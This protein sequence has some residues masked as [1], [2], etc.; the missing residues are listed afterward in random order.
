MRTLLSVVFARLREITRQGTSELERD[1][2]FR[3]HLEME[4]EHNRRRGMSES[5]ARRAAHLSFGGVQQYREATREARGFEPLDRLLRDAR[6]AARRLRRSPSFSFG[7]IATLGV[8]VGAAVAIGALV[9]GVMLRPLPFPEPDRI[10]QVAFRTPGFDGGREHAHSHATYLHFKESGRSFASFGGY[11][12]NDAVNLTDGDDPQRVSAVMATPGVLEVLRAVPAAGRLLSQQDA[13]VATPDVV[14]VMISHRLWQQRYG[15]DPSIIGRTIEVNRRARRVVGVLPAS[16]AF[17]LPV[18]TVWFP[19]DEIRAD[20]WGGRPSLQSRYVTVIARLRD[21]AD[22]ER[23]EQELDAAIPRFSERFPTIT[24]EQV[25]QS[26]AYAEVQPLKDAT[27][28]PVRQHLHLLG[29]TVILVLLI[30]GA[31]VTNLFLLRAERSRHE[32]AI[33]R[34]L[35]AGSGDVARRFVAEGAV[36]GLAG[37]VVALPIVSAAVTSRFGFTAREIPRLHEVT[38]TGKTVTA[39]VA[40]ALVL[41][42]LVSLVAFLR[43]G[44]ARMGLRLQVGSGKVTDRWGVAQRGLVAA[45]VGIALT[46]LVGAA[47]LGRT[48]W[49]LR[50]AELGFMLEGRVTLE[51]TLPYRGYETYARAAAFHAAVMDRLRAIPGVQGADA[52]MEIPLIQEHP[53]E[54]SFELAAVGTRKSER[55]AVNMASPEYFKLMG[56]PLLH[57]RRFAAGDI[58]AAT[59]AIVLSASLARALFDRTDV[60]GRLVRAPSPGDDDVFHQVVGVVGDVPRWRIEDGPA[61][62]AYFPLLRDGDGV[63]PD[64]ARVPI[65]MGT[66]RYVLRTDAPVAQLA[67]SLRSAV[68]EVDARVPVTNVTSLPAIVDAATARVRLTML[69]LGVSAAAALL[70]G[71]IGIYSIVSYTV[72]GRQRELGV[73]LALGATPSRI[74]RMV[75]RDGLV[76]TAAGVAVG[77]VSALWAGRVVQSMLY[78]VSATDPVLYAGVT[79]VLVLVGVAATLAPAHRAAHVNPIEV[80]RAE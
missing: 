55:G 34:A 80:I 1:E 35:G 65:L 51:V 42:A 73:R 43:A 47:L 15:R 76:L 11:H 4:T 61:R 22:I 45:Q 62:M 70:L 50:H 29:V 63:H 7:V 21:G 71:V 57:G 78:G 10:V 24:A 77:L 8:G 37:A 40:T 33:A 75:L 52:A 3:F 60:V 79:A 68:R 25:A 5:D 67:S 72:A 53:G 12:I 48:L 59:P 31:N 18:A 32:V 28:A 14:P 74:Q 2:E 19:L 36:L 17:P 23:A 46:L 58:R 6:Y 39:V 66:A 44:S 56:I 20:R 27:I 38:L 41:G 9:Y 13:E 30:A 54:L 26:R 69:L 64:S 49:N 16:F